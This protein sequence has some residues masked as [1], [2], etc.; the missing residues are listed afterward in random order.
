VRHQRQTQ[1]VAAAVSRGVS[2]LHVAQ[3]PHGEFATRVAPHANMLDEEW[4]PSPFGTTLILSCL[5]RV[6]DPRVEWLTSRALDF[7]ERERESPAVWR[8]ASSDSE[9]HQLY[10]PDL[11]DTCCAAFVLHWFNRP[12]PP[13]EDVIGANATPE[14]RFYTWLAPRGGRPMTSPPNGEALLW[15]I[16]FGQWSDIDAVVNANVLLYLGENRRS[17][18]ALRFLLEVIE[19]QAED[20]C[21]SFYPS[22]LPFYYMVSR[23]YVESAPSLGLVAD[24]V[25]ARVLA[26]QQADNSFGTALE[27][28]LAANVLCNFGRARA[29]SAALDGCI[30]SILAAQQPDGAWP[31]AALFV[32]PTQYYGS[33]ELTTAFCLEALVQYAGAH[34]TGAAP[35]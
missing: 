33:A 26:L 31:S 11:D 1:Q 24:L 3:L 35:C 32:D 5:R 16:V 18:G 17:E 13:N 20:T 19:T 29:S 30:D 34:T 4:F 27:T 14:G 2:F 12:F 10:P 6:A 9:R 28:A 22:R 15:L 8:F 25:I 23:A 21:S 7:L